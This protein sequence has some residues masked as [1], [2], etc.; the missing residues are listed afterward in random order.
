M[1]PTYSLG[2]VVASITVLLAFLALWQWLPGAL[3]VP[4]WVLLPQVP[5]WRWG[6]ESD[7]TPWYP[8]MRLLRQAGAGG[9][10]QVMEKAA[11]SLREFKGA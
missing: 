3:G 8:G 7:K 9:W 11:L 2:M 4:A 1:K 5:D 10:A 6:L